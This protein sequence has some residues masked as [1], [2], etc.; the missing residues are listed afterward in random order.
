MTKL[1]VYNIALGLN[2]KRCTQ[3]ELDSENPPR[4]VSACNLMY[5]VAIKN[6]LSETDW[7]FFVKP[8]DIDYTDDER[9]MGFE[10]GYFIP[11]RFDRIVRVG[12]NMSQFHLA[13][14]RLYTDDERP[15]VWGMPAVEDV[16]MEYAPVNFCNA[17]GIW[18]GYLISIQVSPSDANLGN[19][20][21][22]IYSA[23]LS[24]MMR[25]ETNGS[26][27]NYLPKEAWGRKFE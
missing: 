16:D 1:E 25:A 14:N 12:C 18:L 24:T 9:A 26:N 3:K 21:L 8:I 20:I 17:V 13:D 19:R 5:T 22:Q 10:H 15:E 6:V 4:E 7:S 2:G 11:R 27:D 23:Q